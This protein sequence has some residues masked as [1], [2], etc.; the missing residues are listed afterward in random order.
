MVVTRVGSSSPSSKEG[1]FANPKGKVK[2]KVI[3]FKS[4][5]SSGSSEIIKRKEP[6][7]ASH[8]ANQKAK[9]AKVSAKKVSSSLEGSTTGRVSSSSTI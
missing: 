5:L 8:R 3:A 2:K 9:R 6:Q 7:D 4:K 1:A